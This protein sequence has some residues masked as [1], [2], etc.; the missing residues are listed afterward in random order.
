[1][2]EL[3]H[4]KAQ[5]QRTDAFNLWCS[6]IFLRVPWTAGRSKQSIP[7]ENQSWLFVGR[8]DAEAETPIIWTPN[9]KIRL[10]GKASVP[11]KDWG[12]GEKGETEEEMA[13]W[14]H[15]LNGHEFWANSGKQWRTGKHG[16]LQSMMSQSQIWLG[17]WETTN[18]KKFCSSRG[19]T[20]TVKVRRKK[21]ME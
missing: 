19:I 10:I 9:G 16:I 5:C 13:E 7:K 6:R 4:K 21:D 14:H 20:K 18:F 17:D 1:M 8:T 11:G 2:W 15:W 3:H 12:Q